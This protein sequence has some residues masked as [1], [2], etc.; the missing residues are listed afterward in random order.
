MI[1]TNLSH[2]DRLQLQRKCKNIRRYTVE[3][4][5]LP[6]TSQLMVVQDGRDRLTN[7]LLESAEHCETRAYEILALGGLGHNSG[8]GDHLSVLGCATLAAHP[9]EVSGD[10]IPCMVEKHHSM[11]PSQRLSVSARFQRLIESS[12]ISCDRSSSKSMERTS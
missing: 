5:F 1:W 10:C 2:D 11:R 8:R 4:I 3:H 12:S 7:M 6:T 9:V